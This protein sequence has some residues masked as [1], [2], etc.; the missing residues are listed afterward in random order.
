MEMFSTQLTSLTI[1][2][3][4]LEQ[5]LIAANSSAAQSNDLLERAKPLVKGCGWEEIN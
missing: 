1:C 2:F 4:A 3:L 5:E